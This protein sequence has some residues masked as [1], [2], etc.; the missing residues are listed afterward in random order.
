M[1]SDDAPWDDNHHCSSL[2][3]ASKDH[4]GNIYLPNVVEISMNCLYFH[5]ID[6]KKNLLN[7]E[8][9]VLLDI[10]IKLRI[11]K[12]V[13]ICAYSSP[14]EVK[15]YKSLFQEFLDVFAW[16]YEE[17]PSIYPNIVVHEIKTYPYVNLVQKHLRLVHPKKVVAIKVEVEKIML[18]SFIYPIPLTDWISNIVLVTK[19][20]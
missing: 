4:L 7:I 14:D 10:L 11:V 6:S 2:P 8:E 5:N 15:I 16:S 17:I 18:A 1:M 3:D 12:N 19:K 20:L 13:H 9:I